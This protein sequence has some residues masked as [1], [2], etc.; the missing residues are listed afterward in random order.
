MHH[1]VDTQIRSEND[2]RIK[3]FCYYYWWAFSQHWYWA[4]FEKC[5]FL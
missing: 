3:Y 2:Y 4:R 1:S 5:F